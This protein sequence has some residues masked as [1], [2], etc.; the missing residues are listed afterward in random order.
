[1]DVTPRKQNYI[2]TN[3]TTYSGSVQQNGELFLTVDITQADPGSFFVLE[4]HADGSDV[5]LDQSFDVCSVQT[6]DGRL[7]TILDQR[8]LLVV[9]YK[10]TKASLIV[11][12]V[13][14]IVHDYEPPQGE[15]LKIWAFGDTHHQSN[16]NE[17]QLACGQVDGIDWDFA[18]N[19]GDNIRADLVGESYWV[20]YINQYNGFTNK[21]RSQVYEVIGNHDKTVQSNPNGAD[22]LFKKYCS[23]IPGDNNYFIDQP[24]TP[25]G[26]YLQYSFNVGN[27][28][29]VTLGDYNSGPPPGGEDGVAGSPPAN[30]RA[31]GNIKRSDWDVFKQ[32]IIDNIGKIIIVATH[33]GIKD[34]TVGTGYK[35]FRAALH[36]SNSYSYGENDVNDSDRRGYISMIDNE[37]TNFDGQTG[38]SDQTNEIKSF[39]EQYGE[40]IALVISGHYH[41]RLNDSWNNRGVLEQK[42]NTHFLNVCP[43]NTKV[44]LI[45]NTLTQLSKFIT[46]QGNEMKIETFIHN[47]PVN[48]NPS[49]VYDETVIPLNISFIQ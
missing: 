39:F 40:H 6:H 33:I 29:V 8:Y 9:A 15:I 31:T 24:F 22:Y 16:G 5:I 21:S 10:D 12:P 26:N 47:D 34:T 30:F 45:P 13:Y 48:N 28:V 44:S 27:V 38:D 19:V 7:K 49:G 35:E 4:L 36:Q 43:M 18:I 32:T 23:P 42:Y 14:D 3:D 20:N 41:A 1:M 37:E 46:I 11:N 2:Q 25:T 17:L